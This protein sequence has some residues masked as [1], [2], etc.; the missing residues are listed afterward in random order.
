MYGNVSANSLGAFGTV[1]GSLVNFLVWGM[2][3]LALLLSKIMLCFC[4]LTLILA[5]LLQAFPLGD[6]APAMVATALRVKGFSILSCLQVMMMVRIA[7]ADER[8]RQS[9]GGPRLHGGRQTCATCP[10]SRRAGDPRQG[11]RDIRT[12]RGRRRGP[13][14]RSHT[15][16]PQ[17]CDATIA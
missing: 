16:T 3:S 10:H 14:H 4:M 7:M 6:N 2:F 5:F 11:G 15:D 9:R 13:R 17:P 8:H 12:I 1:L